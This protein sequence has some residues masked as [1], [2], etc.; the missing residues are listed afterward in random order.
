MIFINVQVKEVKAVNETNNI[1]RLHVIANS[2]SNLD[3]ALKLKVRDEIL[4]N[5]EILKY[6][7]NNDIAQN[8]ILKNIPSLEEKCEAVIIENGFNYPI[9]IN[10]TASS[11]PTKVYYQK[12]LPA[13]EYKAVK[14]VIGKGEGKN[15]WC[16]LYP[17]LCHID[18]FKEKENYNILKEEA[19]SV[20]APVAENKNNLIANYKKILLNVWF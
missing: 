15:W 1:I 9:K 11:F 19:I 12:V 18:W 17:P 6:L 5:L 16:V 8:Y 13:G 3:Q 7:R 4:N 2:D 10:L 20:M 14:A